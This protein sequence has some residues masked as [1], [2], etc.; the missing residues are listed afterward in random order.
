ME[1]SD[2][3][4]DAATSAAV[5]QPLL[6]DL[7]AAVQGVMA[8]APTEYDAVFGFNAHYQQLAG[9][10]KL[11]LRTMFRWAVGAEGVL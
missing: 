5:L 1:Q 2:Y 3:A 10:N 7:R 11:V 4:L 9:G 8:A 6:S